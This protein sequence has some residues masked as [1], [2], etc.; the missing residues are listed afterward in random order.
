MTR[1]LRRAIFGALAAGLLAACGG[2][3]E[4]TGAEAETP[5][6][7]P[8]QTG[9]VEAAGAAPPAP[10]EDAAEEPALSEEA[11]GGEPPAEMQQAQAVPHP[12]AAAYRPCAACHLADG[13]GI[14][15]AFPPL[16]AQ[17]VSMAQSEEGRAYLVMS[18]KKGVMGAI[19]IEGQRFR[20]VMPAQSPP[21]DDAGVANVLNY[22]VEELNGAEGV[23]VFTAEEV[24]ATSS[25]HT[26]IRSAHALRPKLEGGDD[27]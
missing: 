8:P 1:G 9:E 25:L 11:A 23:S 5:A 26:D 17:I 3:Q 24:A 27:G 16:G 7:E 10:V 13:Q 18:L 15:G 12:G 19:E 6:A 2:S 21:L 22:V 20:G 4:E 14:P